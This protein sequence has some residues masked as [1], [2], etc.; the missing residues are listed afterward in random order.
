MMNNRMN[1][2]IL[3]TLCASVGGGYSSSLYAESERSEGSSVKG[4]IV[5]TGK[6]PPV[7]HRTVLRDREYCGKTVTY[8]PF[9]IA[10]PSLGMAN[11]VVSV[12]GV[13]LEKT[14]RD[15]TTAPLANKRCRFA[16]HTQVAMVGNALTI[17]SQDPVL[18]NTHLRKDGQTF[19]NI[20]VPPNSRKIR[21]TLRTP[22]RLEV[23]CD[24]HKFMQS[25]V[26]VFNHPYFSLTDNEGAFEI[27][28]IP[29]GDYQLHIWHEVSGLHIQ[30]LRVSPARDV[31][32]KIDL[33]KLK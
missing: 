26:H 22:G 19:L 18:H 33:Q 24:A 15:K 16:P 10:M 23:R 7:E 25:S 21:K 17:T 9:E 4:T 27:S 28:H 11:V 14:S 13:P 1:L 12:E 29:A 30:D 8:R 20:A 5:F 32:V 2:I 31:I 3:F 6:V